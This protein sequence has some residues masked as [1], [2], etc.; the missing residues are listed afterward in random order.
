[1]I[2]PVVFT[3]T[4]G[5]TPVAVT[6][7]EGRKLSSACFAVGFKRTVMIASVPL[8]ALAFSEAPGVIA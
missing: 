8:P 7:V 6:S 4:D 1:M 3:N 5:D 2:V